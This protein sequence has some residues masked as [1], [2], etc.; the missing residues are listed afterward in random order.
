MKL[1]EVY[2]GCDGIVG[3]AEWKTECLSIGDHKGQAFETC[4]DP[5]NDG[6]G[7]D[8]GHT[9]MGLA[10][11]VAVAEIYQNQGL[12]NKLYNYTDQYKDNLEK[13]LAFH[14]NFVRY[15]SRGS[16]AQWPCKEALSNPG[17]WCNLWE[18][19]YSQFKDEKMIDAISLDRP[20]SASRMGYATLT[21]GG[22]GG[23]S[24]GGG[25][26]SCSSQSGKECPSSQ[27][28]ETNYLTVSDSIKCCPSGR[29]K[30]NAQKTADLN[31]DNK[32]GF[33]DLTIL[34]AYW[35]GNS[36][37]NLNKYRNTDFYKG[38]NTRTPDIDV[39]GKVNFDDFSK[40]LTQWG[41]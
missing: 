34:I 15:P 25:L 24:G 4:A 9:Q 30:D 38:C 6:K 1:L 40:F 28:C 35:S 12:G 2:L 17:P 37:F 7:G 32:V 39:D 11:L 22:S 26:E 10:A 21:H 36:N 8:M 31:C 5:D 13:A 41:K 33:K 14:S 18:M 19:A 27:Y 29:C 3:Y 16:N 23:S 20:C